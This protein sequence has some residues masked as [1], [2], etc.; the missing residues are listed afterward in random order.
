MTKIE[1]QIK[2]LE[3][4]LVEDFSLSKS[5]IFSPYKIEISLPNHKK[6]LN[7]S[8]TSYQ[9]RLLESYLLLV[10]DERDYQEFL[11]NY[12]VSEEDVEEINAYYSKLF[13]NFFNNPDNL[14]TDKS[15]WIIF[16][17][18]SKDLKGGNDFTDTIDAV[19]RAKDDS[20]Y[21]TDLTI[22]K[23]GENPVF[24][25]KRRASKDVIGRDGKTILMKAGEEKDEKNLSLSKLTSL[26]Q[27]GDLY[28]VTGGTFN[29]EEFKSKANQEWY[30]KISRDLREITHMST[31][32]GWSSCMTHKRGTRN[33]GYNWMMIRSIKKGLLVGYAYNKP[34]KELNET[35]EQFGGHP[36]ARISINPY[37]TEEGEFLFLKAMKS[38]GT[39]PFNFHDVTQEYLDRHFNKDVMDLDQVFHRDEDFYNDTGI[40]DINP[41][42]GLTSSGG[43][44]GRNIP[45]SASDED[46]YQGMEAGEEWED[47]HPEDFDW[48]EQ[49]SGL[50][51]Y[52]EENGYNIPDDVDDTDWY[53]LSWSEWG[54]LLERD[55]DFA[56][57][58]PDNMIDEL[59]DIDDFIWLLSYVPQAARE[60]NWDTLSSDD[61]LKLLTEHPEYSV[62][63]DWSTLDIDELI[64]AFMDNKK[65]IDLCRWSQL[66]AKTIDELSD[67]ENY[68]G[69]GYDGELF[70]EDKDLYDTV[71]KSLNKE[72]YD[73][74]DETQW[75]LLLKA[76]PEKYIPLW[77]KHDGYKY[78][79][80]KD[81]FYLLQKDNT[82]GWGKINS[83][84]YDFLPLAEKHDAL[85]KIQDD[86]WM[87]LFKQDPKYVDVLI[88]YIDE[89]DKWS[90][91][92]DSM[93]NELL[94]IKPEEMKSRFSKSRSKD[95]LDL[96]DRN[97]WYNLIQSNPQFYA[98][99]A[100]EYDIF[101]I[102]E[103]EE[104]EEY[105]SR[106]NKTQ[107]LNLIA[108]YPDLIKYFPEEKLFDNLRDY[109]W[110]RLVSYNKELKPYFDKYASDATKEL[111]KD[112]TWNK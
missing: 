112:A 55:S 103:E 73:D 9:I 62:Y 54:T 43:H 5:K 39:T 88:D 58:I 111:L 29:P 3:S 98:P 19:F 28:M 53:Q 99:I 107:A 35:E 65:L 6:Q 41:K 60:L 11:S 95:D 106:L 81:W 69:A 70:D 78:M 84:N 40:S 17:V 109:A 96:Y 76:D 91:I 1:K 110:D 72:A 85:R 15:K 44:G 51:E 89:L 32:K 14:A 94:K 10:E 108:K 30:V 77:E 27:N 61:T 7:E 25:G 79:D 31:D 80:S 75:S 52:L 100:N 45:D 56:S 105:P 34:L 59:S 16:K 42:T 33:V 104:R 57:Y 64:T 92:S 23:P 12:D 66:S 36:T 71:N 68:G 26:L 93:W 101:N 18:D 8:L 86:K 49:Y 47:T 83:I 97:K 13:D 74:L 48:R 87:E 46:Y 4:L 102:V 24:K 90:S 82:P 67:P 21:I 20:Y 22:D 63:A 38:Y 2:V 37:S 50:F